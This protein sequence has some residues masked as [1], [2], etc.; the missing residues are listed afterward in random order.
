MF[1]LIGIHGQWVFV[2]P[3]D[4]LVMV[5]TGVYPQANGKS[6]LETVALWDAVVA[7]FGQR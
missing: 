4:E 1:A 3:D 6:V 7:E 5:Q 2:D